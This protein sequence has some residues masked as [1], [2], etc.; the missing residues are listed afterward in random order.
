MRFFTVGSNAEGPYCVIL[1]M[2]KS[3]VAFTFTAYTELMFS[4][5]HRLDFRKEKKSHGARCS[6]TG[7]LFFAK[8]LFT[9]SAFSW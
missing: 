7:L 3:C 1:F 8:Y 5:E 2:F 9:D 6:I 4:Y